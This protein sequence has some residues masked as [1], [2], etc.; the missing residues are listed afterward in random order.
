MEFSKRYDLSEKAIAWCK[1]IHVPPTP[2]N[3]VNALDWFGALHD[4]KTAKQAPTCDDPRTE[5]ERELDELREE[6]R[7]T[8]EGLR[9]DMHPF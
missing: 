9:A 2:L 1:K 5:E 8:Y 6:W 7:E 4:I 3:I